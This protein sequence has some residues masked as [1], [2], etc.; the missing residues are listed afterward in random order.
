MQQKRNLLK[1][2]MLLCIL[3]VFSCTTVPNV[4]ICKEINPD[5]GWCSWTLQKGGFYVDEARPYAFNPKEPEKL[6]TWWEYRPVMMALPPYSWEEL[7]KYIIKQC[8]ITKK[9]QGN[10]GEWFND[11]E[12]KK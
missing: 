6:Y 9:C 3:T 8:K 5:K 12:K 11:L 1:L 7:K 2:T 10:V 4:P